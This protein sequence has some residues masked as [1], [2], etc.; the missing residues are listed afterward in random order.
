[1]LLPFFVQYVHRL[2]FPGQ[3]GSLLLKNGDIWYKTP[4]G[5]GRSSSPI[6]RTNFCLQ[7]RDG[8]VSSSLQSE[9]M[10]LTSQPPRFFVV[11]VWFRIAFPV[12]MLLIAACCL[13]IDMQVVRFAHLGNY[14][15]FIREMVENTE[16]FGHGIG[17]VFVLITA[18]WLNRKHIKSYV[19]IG[20]ITLGAG[21]CTNIAKFVIGRARPRDI[22]V[23]SIDVLQS[24]QGWFPYL[25]DIH[26]SQSFPSGHTT[27]AFAFAVCLS[28]MHPQAK[29]MFFFLAAFV[30]FGRVQ[31]GAHF[32]S[33][34]FAGA[35]MGWSVA[36]LALQRASF[37][38]LVNKLPNS[39]TEQSSEAPV[40]LQWNQQVG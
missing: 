14:P 33:D 7:T 34:V 30:A 5:L 38:K 16:P 1:M 4:G 8:C 12:V 20:A 26:T 35:A 21:L 22:E 15:S 36:V 10:N 25:N 17:V 18:A 39:Q 2:L 23:A 40:I 31:C 29:W 9:P 19:Q 13:T 32:P 11:P 24:F 28:A 6:E 27:V 37:S 3:I